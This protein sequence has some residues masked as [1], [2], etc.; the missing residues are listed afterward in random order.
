MMTADKRSEV[1]GRPYKKTEEGFVDWEKTGQKGVF[2]TAFPNYTVRALTRS[3]PHFEV[4]IDYGLQ[5]ISEDGGTGSSF[6]HLLY[7]DCSGAEAADHP[8]S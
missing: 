8:I 5:I 2:Q 4:A 1:V 7:S 3:N 6:V